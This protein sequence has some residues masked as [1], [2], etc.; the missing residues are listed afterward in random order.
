MQFSLNVPS[1]SPELHL[2]HDKI[3]GSRDGKKGTVA[4]FIRRSRLQRE[5]ARIH[6]EINSGDTANS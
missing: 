4:R 3:S 5:R 2:S 6:S 1:N